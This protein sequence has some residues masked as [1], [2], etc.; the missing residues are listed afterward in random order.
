MGL[1]HAAKSHPLSHGPAAHVPSPSH[2]SMMGAGK[3]GGRKT[4]QTLPLV[5]S[6]ET[7]TADPRAC[8]LAILHPANRAAAGHGRAL[9]ATVPRWG[10]L[11]EGLPPPPA[12]LPGLPDPAQP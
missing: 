4:R 5:H 12:H 10:H 2:W 3:L 7:G 9:G 6:A 11:D 8:T 1:I